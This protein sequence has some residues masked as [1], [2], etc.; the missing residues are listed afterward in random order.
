[1]YGGKPEWKRPLTLPRCRWENNIK[2]IIIIFGA[3]SITTVFF[4]NVLLPFHT[5]YRSYLCP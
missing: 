2:W 5:H 3:L 4:L 1:M